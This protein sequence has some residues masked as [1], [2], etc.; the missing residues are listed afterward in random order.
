MTKTVKREYITQTE[1]P[2]SPAIK[3][4]GYELVTRD[5]EPLEFEQRVYDAMINDPDRYFVRR[6]ISRLQ[7][8]LVNAEKDLLVFCQSN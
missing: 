6:K 1:S 8:D 2:D 5:E 4:K 7:A 3:K